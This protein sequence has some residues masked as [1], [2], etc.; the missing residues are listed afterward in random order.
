MTQRERRNSL[1][2]QLLDARVSR[3]VA[4]KGSLAA[5]AA[6]LLPLNVQVAQATSTASGS[7]VLAAN[8]AAV[9]PNTRPPFRPINPTT[10][11]D[12]VL[13]RGYRYNVVRVYGDDIAAGQPFGY[14]ADYI[15][16]LPLD[17][18][19]GGRSS[20]DGLLWVNHEYPNPLM[21]HG[22]VQGPKTAEQ[23]AIER[24]SVGGSIFRV[25]RERNGMWTFVQDSR[26][27]RISGFTPPRLTGP[28]AGSAFAQ[29]AVDVTGTVG[30]CSGGLTPWGTVLSCEENVNDY[31]APLE[32]GGTGYR[33][34]QSY[35]KEHNW[36]IVEVDPFN[37][38]DTPR[39]H[40]AMGRFR[41]ENAAVMISPTGRVVVYMGDDK[42]DACVFK[43]VTYGAVDPSNRDANLRLLETG[44]LHAADFQNGKWVLL[45]Y[46][47][48]AA[49]QNAT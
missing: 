43:F 46:E 2:H 38:R 42:A 1:W 40:T 17:M 20:T 15:A 16:Y 19:D 45:D 39:K 14:N 8:R 12:L 13:P 9:A 34:D 36:Y 27:R 47:T 48:Q 32:Q 7:G 49:L 3:W 24:T 25:Q 33:W 37:P 11:D 30:N 35:V 10:V 18:L 44:K 5:S 29:G 31:G 23:I 21:Q 26:N 6:S 22:N 4:L 28:I 41:H